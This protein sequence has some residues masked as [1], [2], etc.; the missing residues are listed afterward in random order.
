MHTFSCW[1]QLQAP[2]VVLAMTLV[3]SPV[4]AQLTLNSLTDSTPGLSPNLAQVGSGSFAI[5]LKGSG[6][7]TNSVARLG[8]TNLTT[9]FGDANTLTAAVPSSLLKVA[10]AQGITVIDGSATS[11]SVSLTVTYRGDANGGGTVNMGDALVIARSVGGMPK[12]PVPA[13]LGDL[14]L[15]D[16]VNIGHLH[17]D[18]AVGAFIKIDEMLNKFRPLDAGF[19]LN[20][21]FLR[22]EIENSVHPGHVDQCRRCSKLLPAHGVPATCNADR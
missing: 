12:P 11:T 22:V 8:S 10:G 13:S 9:S 2:A 16:T 14:N 7:S 17:H 4:F 19:N 6:F 21:S 15:S 1:I 20:D 5:T 18:H 3:G